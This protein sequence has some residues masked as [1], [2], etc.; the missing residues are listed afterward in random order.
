[1]KFPSR[2]EVEALRREY[3]AG[4]R[5]ELIGMSDCQALPTGTL[6]TCIAIDDL[7]DLIMKWENGSGLN[8]IP[9]VDSFRI[10]RE[11]EQ[12]D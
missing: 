6:G 8:L 3:P 5:I 11:V 10:V 1:M 9:N 2:A 4:T 12:D 7:G